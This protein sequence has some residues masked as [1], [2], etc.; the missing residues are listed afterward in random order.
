MDPYL[1]HPALWP[2]FH[3]RLVA[4]IADEVTPLV[5][6]RYYVALERR[7]Y[8]LKPDDVVLIGRPDIAVVPRQ[9]ASASALKSRVGTAVLEVDVPMN[10]QVSE[11]FLEVHEV[12]TGMLVTILEF[13][14][15]VNKLHAKGRQDYQEKRG[16]IFQTRT[17]LVEVDFLRAGEPMPVSSKVVSSDY[18]ILVSRGSSRP[19]AQLYTFTLREKI[20]AFPLPLLPGD[21]EPEVDMGAIIHALYDRARFDLRLDYTQPPVP[22]LGGDDAEWARGLITAQ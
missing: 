21:N 22:P 2:D 17:N 9:P 14:S 12:T 6:P 20:P 16:H 5:T 10:D 8:L 4:A 1:E 7:A 13:L 18:R 19:R 11:S 15:P 3:N